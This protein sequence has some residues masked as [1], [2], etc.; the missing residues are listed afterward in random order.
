MEADL[1]ACHA[2]TTR[3]N[4]DGLRLLAHR[5]NSIPLSFHSLIEEY[6]Q[7]G[8]GSNHGGASLLH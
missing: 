7:G 3:V 1:A 2:T 5:S 8:N 4:C 6:L